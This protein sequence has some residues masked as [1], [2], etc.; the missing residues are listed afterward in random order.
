MPRSCCLRRSLLALFWYYRLGDNP[1]IRPG[2]T[3]AANPLANIGRFIAQPRLRLA[4]VIAF[5]RSCFWTTFFV[6]GPILMVVTGEGELA[7][8]LLVSAGN[9]LLFTA[10]FWGRAGKRFGAR[11]IMTLAFFAMTAM[12]FAAG[13]C[14][15]ELSARDRRL[16]A[17]L[18]LFRHRSGCAGLDGRS[19]A[20]CAPSSGRRC[21]LSTAPISTFR[22]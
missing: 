13:F 14:R 9:A 18:R 2:K 6:Y 7:G 5:G 16:S 3:R 4:W 17:L 1:L 19:C 8:G 20:R 22:N 15:R 10:V 21:R 11:N 12:L